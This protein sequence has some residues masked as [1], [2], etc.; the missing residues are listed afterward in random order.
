MENREKEATL[1]PK[2]KDDD[3]DS[4]QRGADTPYNEIG[5]YD[6]EIT[7]IE[8][9]LHVDNVSLND[10]NT[11][12]DIHFCKK[13]VELSTTLCEYDQLHMMSVDVSKTVEADGISFGNCKED[14]KSEETLVKEVFSAREQSASILFKS[15]V[16]KETTRF[17][18]QQCHKECIAVQCTEEHED[19]TPITNSRTGRES[20]TCN[21]S[22]ISHR[23]DVHVATSK[24]LVPKK[25]GKEQ[26]KFPINT[27][28]DKR[29]INGRFKPG[30]N[31]NNSKWN[32]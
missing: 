8:A 30:R 14:D 24:P 22:T 25:E 28:E 26:K 23:N 31:N 27:T 1:S 17:N 7:L 10:T 13:N 20:K 16:S 6:F 11:F 15:S 29:K 3:T 32:K 2:Y 21:N 9:S 4:N 19:Y 12:R 5:L 18:I